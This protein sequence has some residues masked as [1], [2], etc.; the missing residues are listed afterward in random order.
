VHV[1]FF[2]STTSGAISSRKFPMNRLVPMAVVP[3]LAIVLA[4]CGGGTAA[5][6]AGTRFCQNAAFLA[7]LNGSGSEIAFL[8]AHA[9][10]IDE[11]RHQAPAAVKADVITFVTGVDSAIAANDP[12]LAN[13]AAM[14]HASSGMKTYC[15][16][17]H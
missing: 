8:K 6:G 9:T 16:I 15:G 11:L 5:P 17:E 10:R 1:S 3:V 2:R 12:A 13:T 14:N 7:A 4:A